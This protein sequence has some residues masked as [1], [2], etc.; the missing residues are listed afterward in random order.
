M[1]KMD[2]ISIWYHV[3][4]SSFLF[5]SLFQGKW[6]WLIEERKKYLENKI[7]DNFWETLE[8]SESGGWN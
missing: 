1:D 6:K 8:E 5:S 3:Q 7:L 2:N 4:F